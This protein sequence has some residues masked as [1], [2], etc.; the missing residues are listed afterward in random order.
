MR[1]TCFAYVII[2]IIIIIILKITSINYSIWGD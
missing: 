2:I 1:A